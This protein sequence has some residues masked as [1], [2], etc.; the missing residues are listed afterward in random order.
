VQAPDGSWIL[1]VRVEHVVAGMPTWLPFKDGEVVE[2]LTG[3]LPK[4]KFLAKL[5]PYLNQPKVSFVGRRPPVKATWISRAANDHR[6]GG[7][8]YET[9]AYNA[10]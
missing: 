2:R 10:V 7:F 8:C 4:T 6:E 3:Y 5:E 9:P 1:D